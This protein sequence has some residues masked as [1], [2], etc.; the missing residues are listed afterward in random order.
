[1]L[2]PMMGVCSVWERWVKESVEEEMREGY[3]GLKD[4]FMTNIDINLFRGLR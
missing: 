1:M 3:F 4:S 2:P